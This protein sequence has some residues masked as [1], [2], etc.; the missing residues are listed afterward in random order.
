MTKRRAYSIIIFAWI[1]SLTISLA[2]LMGLKS[3]QT[4][5][6]ICEINENFV[7]ALG[8]ASFSFYIPL[9][10]ILVIY[11][12]IFKEARAQ[13]KFIKTG[14]KKV[15]DDPNLTLRVHIGPSNSARMKQS[16]SCYLNN[17]NNQNNNNNINGGLNKHKL[18]DINEQLIIDNKQMNVNNSKKNSMQN[19]KELTKT[20]SLTSKIN[21]I[22]RFDKSMSLDDQLD[23]TKHEYC[24]NC[25]ALINFSKNN[26]TN[27]TKNNILTGSSAVLNF[28]NK[29]AKFKSEQKAAKTLSIVV[30]CLV[31]CWAPFFIV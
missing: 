8:S 4:S 17:H 25:K 27:L 28:S 5:N 19:T 13:I 20:V 1:L 10:I 15:N 6:K 16:C 12:K 23:I 26:F 18:E 11:Y 31:C 14:T 3:P 7:Y 21:Q 30:G 22:K 2:P 29:I 24:Q 9:S